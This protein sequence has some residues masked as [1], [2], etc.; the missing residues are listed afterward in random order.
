MLMLSGGV[1]LWSLAHLL[2]RLS[3]S[4]RESLGAI[5][6][7]IIGVAI[8][9]S[10]VMMVMGY[11]QAEPTHFWGRHPAMVGINNLLMLIA[12]YL[13]VVSIVKSSLAN[14]IRHLQL[15]AVKT[16]AIAH[17]LVNGDTASFVLFGGL[18]A[19]AVV[20]VILIGKAG[21]PALTQRPLS[22]LRE[23]IAL[24]V[25]LLVYGGI[26]MAHMKLGYPVFG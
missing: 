7:G 14:R 22:L 8:L 11:S 2:K 15:T 17:L 1:V 23:V 19:W 25:T 12:V 10:V 4:F 26:A 20:S 3:P 21:K 24:G 6:K 16:W 5:G 13:M 18:L 9:L